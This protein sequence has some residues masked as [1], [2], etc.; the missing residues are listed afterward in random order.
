MKDTDASFNLPLVVNVFEGVLNR[1]DLGEEVQNIA[2]TALS[3]KETV[4]DVLQWLVR[5]PNLGAN[6]KL[7][8]APPE[9]VQVAKGEVE[10]KVVED[11]TSFTAVRLLFSLQSILMLAIAMH[12][13]DLG[14]ESSHEEFITREMD[15]L[16]FPLDA[17]QVNLLEVADKRDQEIED[18]NKLEPETLAKVKQKTRL[19]ETLI[20][21]NKMGK[22][23]PS[24]VAGRQFGPGG[25]I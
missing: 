18:L 12:K 8:S 23:L 15:K 2:Q 5:V 11:Q 17:D 4:L 19:D 7:D 13:M 21:I 9:G 25:G 20:I 10:N 1:H 24:S 22:A 16:G 3:T 14:T 6:V